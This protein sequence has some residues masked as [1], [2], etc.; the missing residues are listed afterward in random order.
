MGLFPHTIGKRFSRAR[1]GASWGGLSAMP[2]Q[3]HV[4]PC[5]FIRYPKMWC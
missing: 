2:G 5:I 1:T 4:Q 3:D